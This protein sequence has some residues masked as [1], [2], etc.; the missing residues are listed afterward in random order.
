MSAC[1][2]AELADLTYKKNLMSDVKPPASRDMIPHT[3]AGI[4]LLKKGGLQDPNHT[5]GSCRHHF[6]LRH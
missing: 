1:G 5:G 6:T 2:F 4:Q 3:R